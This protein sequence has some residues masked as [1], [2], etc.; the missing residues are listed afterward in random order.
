MFNLQFMWK[1]VHVSWKLDSL[2]LKDL[3]WGSM[4]QFYFKILVNHRN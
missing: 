4:K 1:T 3:I 2:T